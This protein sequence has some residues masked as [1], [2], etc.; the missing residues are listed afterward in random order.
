VIDHRTTANDYFARVHA[1][2]DAGMRE[3][4]D[5]SWSRD[6]DSLLDEIQ[7]EIEDISGWS[8]LLWHRLQQMRLALRRSREQNAGRDDT[9]EHHG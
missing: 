7:Q 5:R 6:P 9:A 1:R 3:Y 4:G 8:V 2:L